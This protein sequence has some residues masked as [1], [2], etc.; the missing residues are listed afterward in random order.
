[1]RLTG[2]PAESSRVQNYCESSA[3]DIDINAIVAMKLMCG[4]LRDSAIKAAIL[5][6]GKPIHCVNPSICK[7]GY[8]D[9]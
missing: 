2:L 5:I 8:F 1:M 9:G 4:G 7:D 6:I 3:S